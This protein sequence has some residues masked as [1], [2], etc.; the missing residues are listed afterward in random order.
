MTRDEARQYFVDKGLSY[1][2]I[3]R[4]DLSLLGSMLN[5]NFAERRL[6]AMETGEEPFWIRL[7][8]PKDYGGEWSEN[9]ALICAFLTALGENFFSRGVVSF[10]RDGYIGLC[11]GVSDRNASLV[12]EAFVEWCDVL[13]DLKKIVKEM[14]DA[15]DLY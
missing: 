15:A 9:G 7:H 2:D 3:T 5:R 4:T 11:G 1:A 13:A 8:Q 6:E 12:L 10:N 14:D